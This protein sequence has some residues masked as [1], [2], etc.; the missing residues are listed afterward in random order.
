MKRIRTGNSI[1]LLYSI[2]VDNEDQKLPEDLTG[3]LV[4]VELRNMPYRLLV[5]IKPIILGNTI[6]I[7]IPGKPMLKL[8]KYSLTVMYQKNGVDYALDSDVFTI[9]DRSD[10]TGGSVCCPDMEVVAVNVSGTVEYVSP[11]IQSDWN[12]TNTENPAFIK[13]KPQLSKIATSGSY[14]DLSGTPSIPTKVSNLTNDTGYVTKAVNDLESYYRK[15]ETYTQDQILNL[16][17]QIKTVRIEKVDFLPQVGEANVI[18]LVQK[19]GSEQDVFNELIYIEGKY[20]IIG[21]TQIDL[22]NYVTTE[23]AEKTYQKQEAGKGLTSN[24]FTDVYKRMLDSMRTVQLASYSAGKYTIDAPYSDLMLVKFAATNVAESTPTV[25]LSS[26]PLTIYT[27]KI[28]SRNARPLEIVS[29][30]FAFIYF[31][32]GAA[33]VFAVEI[34]PATDATALSGLARN[35]YISPATLKYVLDNRPSTAASPAIIYSPENLPKETIT[36]SFDG[37]NIPAGYGM[38]P[39]DIIVA[40]N[41]N[42]L[43]V[44]TVELDFDRVAVRFLTGLTPEEKYINLDMFVGTSGPISSDQLNI[45]MPLLQSGVSVGKKSDGS[46]FS[47][48]V[49]P[50]SQ[51]IYYIRYGLAVP[52]A[53]K[54]DLLAYEIAVSARDREYVVTE[55]IISD[56]ASKSYVDG[57]IGSYTTAASIENLN[58]DYEN[59]YVTLTA[60]EALS[61]NAFGAGYNGKSITVYIYSSA[62]RTVIIPT[63]GNY[64]SMCGSSY[65]L[66]AGKWVEFN[67]KGV[68][69]TWHIAK[70]EQE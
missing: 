49:E 52:G 68:E 16:I 46:T 64:V 40:K 25:V 11:Q 26:D 2:F 23:N 57:K 12:E 69:G 42:L 24:D 10:E 6:T 7:N 59:I 27:L 55:N 35:E 58:S 19:I 43:I 28:N 22:S 66:P 39:W 3:I 21:N 60:N 51:G 48:S 67:F 30:S 13:N 34:D 62:A 8:G 4:S 61:V 45:L 70:L 56:I 20:E 41:G 17:G 32:R 53:N 1:N 29:Q 54:V 9:V 65:D 63:T 47:L 50:V 18:Y 37:L 5:P 36:I 44:D 14:A 38:Q 31:D 33:N 15:A